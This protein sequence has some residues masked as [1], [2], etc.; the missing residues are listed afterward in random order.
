M[1]TAVITSQLI[2]ELHYAHLQVGCGKSSLLNSIIGEIHVTSG[3]VTSYGSIAYVPQVILLDL[4]ISS[5][6]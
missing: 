2:E 3:S 4:E 6:L 5:V 1:A